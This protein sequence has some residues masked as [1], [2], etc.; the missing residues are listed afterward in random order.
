MG[1]YQ[2]LPLTRLVEQFERLPGIGHKTAQRLAYHVLQMPEE[3][4]N[5]FAQTIL[6]A[7]KQVRYCT[8][9]KNVT[10]RE[11]C[12]ICS[13]TARDHSVICVV[14]DPRAGWALERSGGREGV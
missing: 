3:K 6:E 7:R 10:D 13:D 2:V 5:L 1:A 9:C 11:I 14:E 8:V 4:A 12:A